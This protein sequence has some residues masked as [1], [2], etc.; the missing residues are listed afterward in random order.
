MVKRYTKIVRK[1]KKFSLA[2]KGLRRFVLP[3]LILLVSFGLLYIFLLRDLPSPTRLNK[4]TGSFSTQIYDRKGELLYTIFSDRNQTFVPLEKI[5]KDLQE[6]TIAVED[7]D[8]YRH[9]AIDIRGIGRSLYSIVVY[10]QLQGG[11]TLTQQLV[12]NSLLTPER[13]IQR[14]VKEVI[15]A[16]AIE[17]LYGKEEIIEMYL[18]QVPYGGTA[19]GVEAA[20]QAFFGKHVNELTLAENA[21]LAGLPESP[22]T[23]SPFGSR[24]ELGKKRQ[25]EILR[26]MYEQK[27]ITKNERDKALEQTL[28]FQKITNPIKAPHFVFYVKDLLIKKYGQSAVEQGGL[29]VVT[30]LDLSLQDFAQATVAS[31]VAKVKHYDVG[32]GAAVVTNPATGE[33]LAMV[34]GTNYFDQKHGN[35]NV[36]IAQ[37]QPGSSIKP[38]NYAVGLMKGYSAAT[39]FIDAP[40]CFPNNPGEKPY[41][42]RNYDGR[43]RGLV[44]MRQ[45]LAQSLNIPAVQM[46]KLNTIDSMIKTAGAMGLKLN[47]PRGYGLS[48]TLGGAGVTM[49]DMSEAFGVFANQ[50]YRVD[51]HPILKVTDKNGKV[52]EE[53]K[54]PES[55]IFGKRVL[56]SEVTFIISDILADN[57]ARTPAFGANSEL[58][59]DNNQH[60]S[61]KT[62][63]TNDYRD[64]W[65]IGYTPSYLVTVWVGNNDNSAMSGIVSGVTGAAPIWNTIMSRLLEGKKPEIPQKPPNVFS[66]FACNTGNVASGDS[67]SNDCAGRYEYFI[68][69]TENKK[70]VAVTKEKVFIDKTTNTL[71]KPGQTENV[72]EREET[73]LRDA[74]GN[75]YCATCPR[76][77]PSLS[78]S[79]TP[80]PNP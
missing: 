80:S 28:R 24:P 18:N 41:C 33:I 34:G 4:T 17:A 9:G 8:F 35:V 45:A 10:K 56:P 30:S 49:L 50:G 31:E 67:G 19:Y 73:F 12:K 43:F 66:R 26:K 72:E 3:V 65:T 7:K 22:S 20:A 5:P 2:R 32:N 46:L 47:D 58:K 29:K 60:V 11:S 36:A 6:A 62:G 61:V 63:T 52:L 77:E 48:L 74:L 54:P 69:G 76:S 53:Y 59:I 55:P 75:K 78:P 27:Y 21:Y 13:T 23:Y 38:I 42:P 14:K 1:A 70:N 39:P 64:N 15:L 71:A 25:E 16:F 40:A 57:R 51:L 68:K 37:R 79:P 44:T